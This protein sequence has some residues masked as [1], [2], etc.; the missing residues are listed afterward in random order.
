MNRWIL[1]CFLI[2]CSGLA[3]ALAMPDIAAAEDLNGHSLS[4]AHQENQL[5]EAEVT[6]YAVSDFTVLNLVALCFVTYLAWTV[7]RYVFLRKRD[8]DKAA[9]DRLKWQVYQSLTTSLDAKNYT[10]LSRHLYPNQLDALS[11]DC[12]V[13]SP[14]GVFVVVVAEQSGLVVVE[15]DSQVWPCRHKN[16]THYL[17]NPLTAAAQRA[18]TLAGVLNTP[19]GVRWVVVFPDD[20]EFSPTRPTDCCKVSEVSLDILRYTRCQFSHEQVRLFEQAVL[21]YSELHKRLSA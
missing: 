10:I 6:Q 2:V 19:F 21:S 17:A 14:F 3:N 18:S 5:V 1:A 16:K 12:V 4:A 7:G 13:L 8:A 9:A 11:L 20:A 15:T